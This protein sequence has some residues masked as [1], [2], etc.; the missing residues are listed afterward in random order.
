MKDLFNYLL[1]I[2]IFIF[3]VFQSIIFLVGEIKFNPTLLCERE[4]NEENVA[5]DNVVLNTSTYSGDE[6]TSVLNY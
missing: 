3:C 2:N 4:K 5:F 6:R 1:N